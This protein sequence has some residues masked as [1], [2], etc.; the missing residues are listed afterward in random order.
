MLR[1]TETPPS[2]NAHHQ[3]CSTGTV[4]TLPTMPWRGQQTQWMPGGSNRLNCPRSSTTA[5]CCV[6]THCKQQKPSQTSGYCSMVGGCALWVG[7]LERIGREAGM[8]LPTENRGGERLRGGVVTRA[9]AVKTAV[10][11]EVRCKLPYLKRLSKRSQ[12][13]KQKISLYENCAKLRAEET[14]FNRKFKLTLP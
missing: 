12:C 3:L 5:T 1:L 6:R 10:P 7:E 2:S 9:G 8:L 13:I 14:W 4:L 11:N